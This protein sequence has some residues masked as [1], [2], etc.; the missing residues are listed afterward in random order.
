MSA[1]YGVMAEFTAGE[2]VVAAARAARDAGYV[3]VE[4]YSPYPVAGVAAALG[5]RTRLAIVTFVAA[6]IGAAAIFLFEG[7]AQAID[8]TLDVGGRRALAATAFVVPAFELAIL[9]AALATVVAMFARDGLPAPYHPLFGVAAFERAS[10]DRF[11]LVVEA[12]DP[13]FEAGAVRRFLDSL[14]PLEVYDVPC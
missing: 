14:A 5:F 3:A 11:F 8:W 2:E 13:R 4:V 6:V 1:L 12:S 7:W 9:T 10:Q